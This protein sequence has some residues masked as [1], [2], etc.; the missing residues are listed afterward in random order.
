MLQKI[1]D[2]MAKIFIVVAIVS[3][4]INIVL[5]VIYFN[6][7][8]SNKEFREEL[9]NLTTELDFITDRNKQLETIS[10]DLSGK[11]ADSQ[12]YVN[13]LTDDNNELRGRIDTITNTN[14]ESIE[15]VE[16]IER[17]IADSLRIVNEF[18]K[19]L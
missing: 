6:T 16:T 9:A 11:L 5:A 13:E 17:L 2:T 4:I 12:Q 19:E 1:Q 7:R 14:N 10:N 8:K 3:I 18:E 15:G